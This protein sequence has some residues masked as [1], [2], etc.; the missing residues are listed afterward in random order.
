[1]DDA[2]LENNISDVDHEN[3]TRQT[4]PGVPE[5]LLRVRVGSIMMIIINLSVIFSFSFYLII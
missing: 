5:H 1:M 4:P 3:L 2:S